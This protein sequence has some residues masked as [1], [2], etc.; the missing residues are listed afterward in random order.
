MLRNPFMF[1]HTGRPGRGS[2]GDTPRR[3]G[4][5]PNPPPYDPRRAAQY[6]VQN[7]RQIRVEPPRY[8]FRSS[9]GMWQRDAAPYGQY[10]KVVRPVMNPQAAAPVQVSVV[11]PVLEVMPLDASDPAVAE[12]LKQNPK[13]GFLK[14]RI[15]AAEGLIPVANAVAKIYVS[16]AGTRHLIVTDQSDLSGMTKPLPL[17]TQ[18]KQLTLDPRNPR[19]YASYEVEVEHPDYKKIQI[20]GVPVFDGIT[21]VQPVNLV[22]SGLQ[23]TSGSRPGA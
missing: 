6:D 2:G 10:Q 3:P 22:P 7:T 8:D 19:P 1:Q 14:L 15:A 18:D 5:T 4:G 17:P 23:E 12:F 16:I 13:T 21:S 11:H 9:A 20:T